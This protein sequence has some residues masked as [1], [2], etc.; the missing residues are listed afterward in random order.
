M[1]EVCFEVVERA[2]LDQ[3][4][5][6]NTAYSFSKIKT[7][8]EILI[9]QQM[10]ECVMDYIVEHPFRKPFVIFY[11]PSYF[12]SFDSFSLTQFKHWCIDT[13]R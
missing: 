7:C 3:K 4:L 2:V 10:S 11:T 6:K 1:H 13:L 5:S 12:E 8:A 9:G